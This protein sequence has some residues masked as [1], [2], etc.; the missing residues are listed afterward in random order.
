MP[1]PTESEPEGHCFILCKGISSIISYPMTN[2]KWVT[3]LYFC[4]RFCHQSCL[5]PWPTGCEWHYFIALPGTLINHISSHDQQQVSDTAL[6][7]CQALSSTMSHP[8]I[9]RM[10]VTLLYFVARHSHQSCL[11]PWPTGSEWHSFVSLPGTLINHVSSNDQQRVS[12]TT[13]FL[14]HALSSITIMSHPMTNS[15]WV[16]L[17]YFFARHSHDHVKS[18]DQQIVSDTAL[19]LCQALSSI[20][21]HPMTNS[22]WVTL[23]Y[24][25]AR[26][27]H[28]SCLILWPTASEWH[29]IISLPCT[30]I[31]H[32][33]SHDH[34][35]FVSDTALF[36]CQALSCLIPWPTGCEWCCLI[37][38]PGTLINHVSSHDQ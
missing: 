10:W 27:S 28:Q 7:L 30:L 2:R 1:W 16:T 4:A 36:L 13:V 23:L 25:F 37:S 24:C 38:L 29:C 5:I 11:I 14:C 15:E 18:H 9:N 17:L 3:L 12:D 35:Q 19:F 8:M 34:W 26:H 22:K 32:V 21:S 33:S 20:M 31:N 6:S